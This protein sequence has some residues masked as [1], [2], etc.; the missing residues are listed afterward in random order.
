MLVG[1]ASR[2]T[3][4]ASLDHAFFLQLPQLLVPQ[5]QHLRRVLAEQGGGGDVNA[6]RATAG[7]WESFTVV[8]RGANRVALRTAGGYYLCAEGGG[9]GA[10]VANRTSVGAWE[11]FEVVA[12]GGGQIALRTADGHYLCAEGGGGRAVVANR[13]GVGGWETFQ[14]AEV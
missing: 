12:V 4:H 3:H 8:L 13:T 5:P 7:A 11:T 10:V 9:G 1:H 2:I 6:N 14:F